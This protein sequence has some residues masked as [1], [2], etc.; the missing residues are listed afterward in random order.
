[1]STV[2]YEVGLSGTGQPVVSYPRLDFQPSCFFAVG[3]PIA[4]FLTVRGLTNIQEDFH[5]PT[6]P[7]F[8]NIFHPFDPVAYRMEPFVVPSFSVKPVLVPHHKGRKRMHLEIRESLSRV[9]NDL[10][11]LVVESIRSTWNSINDFARAHRSI[12]AQVEAMDR[13]ASEQVMEED[14][15]DSDTESTVSQTVT[16]VATTENVAVG[17]LNRGKRFDYVLQEKPIESFNEYLFALQSHMC[18]WE[19]E[20][21]VLLV[22]KEVYATMG[23]QPSFQHRDSSSR[24]NVS[25]LR[26]SIS[27]PLY[28]LPPGAHTV[29]SAFPN[30]YT[31][32]S[33][34]DT[35]FA[36]FYPQYGPPHAGPPPQMPPM[37]TPSSIPLV[38]N[39][40]GLGMNPAAPPG[41]P[42]GSVGPPPLMGFVR[43]SAVKK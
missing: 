10:K 6:C 11:Q 22:L 15:N 40:A 9:G 37:Q 16:E 31:A 24:A 21:T 26:T 12:T 7:A 3:S 17:K 30:Q 33:A 2:N 19:S 4:M 28:P 14:E 25:R 43:Q 8:Y 41:G 13:F 18:Y 32:R 5:L 29:P 34:T 42:M 36:P 23:I 39:A 27:A 38:N 20:D 35:P 1:M